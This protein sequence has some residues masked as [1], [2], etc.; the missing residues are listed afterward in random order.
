MPLSPWLTFRHAKEAVRNGRPEEAHRLLAPLAAEG[1]R[2][3]GRLLRDVA[4]AYVARGEKSHRADNAEAAWKDLLAAEALNTGDARVSTL[5]TALTRIGVAECAAALEAA[6]PMHVLTV[7]GRLRDRHTQR[8]DLD[9]ME[10]LAQ[11]W[12]MAH[13]M[14]DRGDFLLAQAAV[15]K[16]R[17]RMVMNPTTG[18]DLFAKQLEG[19]HERYRMAVANLSEAA[20]AN[21]WADASRWAAEVIAAAPNHREART[22]QLRAWE[23]LKPATG[24][25]HPNAAAEI[26]PLMAVVEPHHAAFAYAP[27]KAAESGNGHR[28]ASSFRP[29]SRHSSGPGGMPKRFL[30]WIDGVGGYLV[31][32]SNRVTFGQA[33]ADAPIDVPLFADVSRMHAEMARDGEGYLVESTRGLHVNGSPHERALL[34]CGDRV[35]LG[36]SCQFLFRQPVSISPSARL[37]LVS[38]HRLPLAVDGVLL[39]ADN[40]ILG[41]GTQTHIT[42]PW[43]STN[44]ILYRSKDGL[45]VKFAGSFTVDNSPCRERAN[46][47]LPASVAAEAFSFTI[48]PVGARL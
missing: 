22:I 14:A 16:I 4:A 45:G 28:P 31:C 2:K 47:V 33:T 18:L 10:A 48:E 36:T 6:K 43:A 44:V 37:E 8:H 12:V 23:A 27:T 35:T 9:T 41:P 30:L 32:L 7:V 25:Y 5:R 3:A 26:V 29:E 21:K 15:D 39:M 40:L 46:L 11:D 13:E 20:E 42:L 38:G 34:K 1:Y 17:T 24:S 19:R